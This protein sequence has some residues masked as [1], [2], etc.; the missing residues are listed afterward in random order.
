M[1]EY[2]MR[3]VR[4]LFALFIALMFVPTVSAQTG[5]ALTAQAG[6][7][8]YYKEGQWLPLRV[9]LTNSGPELNGYVRVSTLRASGSRLDYTYP[10]ALASGARKE[11]T[12]YVNVEGFANR[13]QVEYVQDEKVL[14]TQSP[15]LSQVATNDLLYGV[16]ATNA[17]A[18]NFLGRVDPANG[19]GRLAQLTLQDL[20][21]A[22][23]AWQA[24]DVLVFAET[25]TSLLAAA[26]KDALKIWLSNGGRLILVGGAS[27]QKLN[28][29]DDLLPLRIAGTQTLSLKSLESLAATA[30]PNNGVGVVAVGEL[31]GGATVLAAESG[32]PLLIEKTYGAGRIAFFAVDPTLD[33]LRT[34]GGMENIYR[35]ILSLASERPGWMLWTRNW[36]SA[37]EAIGAIPGLGLPHPLLICGFLAAYL[38]LVGPVNYLFLRAIKRREFAWFTIPLTVILFTV[39]IYF[40]GLSLRGTRPTL[41]RLSVVQA[42]EGV[43]RA[44]VESVIGVFSP[45]RSEY[46]LRVEGD[47]LLQ[48]LPADNYYR[49]LDRSYDGIQFQQGDA[50]VARGIKVDVGAVTPFLTRGQVAAPQFSSALKYTLVGNAVTLEGTVVNKSEL[51]L[52][53]A[54]LLT[55]SGVQRVGTFKPNDT[56]NIKIPLVGDRATWITTGKTHV[57]S[58]NTKPA[59]QYPTPAYSNSD[60]TLDSLLDPSVTALDPRELYRRQA[61]LS[62]WLT[63]NSSGRGSGTYLF[64]WAEKSPITTTLTNSDF[65]VQDQTLHVW[66]V[67]PQVVINAATLTIP[68][69]LMTW[70]L[71][72]PGPSGNTVTPYDA[73]L[74]AGYFILR[75]QAAVQAEQKMV[76]TLV[77][78]LASYGATGA[79]PFVL[80]LWDNLEDQ[81]VKIDNVVWGDLTIPNP[82]RFVGH[83]GRIDVKVEL[84]RSQTPANIQTLDFTL[85]TQR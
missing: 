44:Q 61:L 12:L 48:P 5:L 75:F 6:F 8:A 11:L 17:S 57:F 25:D 85:T 81:W 26:Q 78:H 31:K 35:H 33:P 36:A 46:D 9:S 77:L 76:Q 71:L 16:V 45:T 37:V 20:P 42:W 34:W 21:T 40:T 15:R 23:Q 47:L 66:R 41:H 58:V 72:D 63:Y 18:F 27:W 19:R 65:N 69:S 10:I 7:D 1:V 13:L 14:A 29:L 51:T 56:V 28:G 70:E 4:I 60:T 32:F 52:T 38:V 54:V 83:E 84:L 49:A 30:V 53:D 3:V 59:P 79:T 73:R 62:W 2:L 74:N 43:P 55:M 82:A 39:A 67:E 22:A 64:G 24:L 50:A 80:Y 68:P